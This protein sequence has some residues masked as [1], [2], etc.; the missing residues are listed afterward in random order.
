MLYT[1]VLGIL[2]GIA[3]GRH[4][5]VATVGAAAMA[6]VAWAWAVGFFA[7]HGFLYAACE[8]I[9]LT[10]FLEFGLLLGLL[11]NHLVFHQRG[12]TAVASQTT[13]L[14]DEAHTHNSI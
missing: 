1:A 4:F 12:R 7:G 6:A 5:K 14:R 2:S 9:F 3:F 11:L 8:A 13:A 10:W